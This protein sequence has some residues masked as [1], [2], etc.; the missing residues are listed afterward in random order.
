VL[1]LRK[2]NPDDFERL[3]EID[4]ACFAEGIA[5]SKEEMRYFLRRPSAIALVGEGG[6]GSGVEGFIIA[7]HF[8][9]RR[10]QQSMG[11]IITIDVLPKARR[12]GLGSRLL[13]AVEEELQA[14]GCAYVSLEVAVDNQ[15][16]M[17]F[18]KKHGYSGLKILPRYYLDSIDALLMGKKLSQRTC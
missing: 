8:R 15:A 9:P 17:R 3:L 7:D 14:V 10:S 2:Y 1:T 18:Y 4:Q 5:Y 6:P 12:S 13:D 16:A 11:R